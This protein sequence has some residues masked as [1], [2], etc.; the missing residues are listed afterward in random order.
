VVAAVSTF[1]L[2]FLADLAPG[3]DHGPRIAAFI[4]VLAQVFWKRPVIGLPRVTPWRCL[5]P[6]ARGLA[7]ADVVVVVAG[8]RSR[9]SASRS[10][11]SLAPNLTHALLPDGGRQV[12][13]IQLDP[14]P[15]RIKKCLTHIHGVD[16]V[17]SLRKI[18]TRLCLENL[19]VNGTSSA[20]F[21][22][23]FLQ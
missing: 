8:L 19:C 14:C 22:S 11:V 21:A 9:A 23:T 10:A 20:S 15:L 16:R 2:D 4:D 6:P 18:W 12:L 7:P 1:G 5:L 3:V 13:L 17:R